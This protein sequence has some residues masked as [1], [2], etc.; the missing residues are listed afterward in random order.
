M[1]SNQEQLISRG[2]LAEGVE[3]EY[4][5]KSFN[6]KIE[7]LQCKTPADRTLGAR[8]LANSKNGKVIDCLINAL[9]V[10]KKLYTKIEICNSLVS[11]GQRSIKPLIK[12]LG[13]I[14]TNQHT[15]V[16]EKEFKK[17][18]YPLPR[19]IAGR[20]LV[21]FGQAALNELEKVLIGRDIKQLSEAID[22][23]GFICFYDCKPEIYAKLRNCYSKNS[24]NNL[25][26][27]KIIRAMSG[28]PESEPFLLEQKQIIRHERLQKEIE[29]SLLLIKKRT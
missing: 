1:K 27:W 7:L 15:R 20:T 12:I 10:E 29:R 18:S 8:L 22:A 11:C 25:I 21:C 16:Y 19:D 28:F 5:H 9:T 13:K 4:L 24:Q 2:Y 17:D 6:E 26:R 14:G 3:S 23:V